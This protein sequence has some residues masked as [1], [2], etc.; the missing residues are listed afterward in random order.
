M[1]GGISKETGDFQKAVYFYR[2]EG[3]S[4]KSM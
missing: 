1:V 4:K 3:G 2:I